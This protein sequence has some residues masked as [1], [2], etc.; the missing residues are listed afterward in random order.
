MYDMTIVV[1]YEGKAPD[2]IYF[3]VGRKCDAISSD[4]LN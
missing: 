2:D 1:D 3:M 4:F